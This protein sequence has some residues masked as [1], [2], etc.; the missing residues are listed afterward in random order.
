MTQKVVKVGSS[1]A[2]I[3]PKRSLE[4]LGIKIGD[5]VSIATNKKRRNFVVEPV[6]RRVEQAIDS[7]V[8]AWTKKFIARYRPALKALAR[9]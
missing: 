9:K 3:I 7:E 2:V 6:S 4:E 8:R 5:R 1:A